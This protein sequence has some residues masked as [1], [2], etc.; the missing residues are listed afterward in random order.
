VLLCLREKAREV[1]KS[2]IGFVKVMMAVLSPGDLEPHLPAV[3]EGLMLWAGDAKNRFRAKIKVMLTKLCRKFGYDAIQQLV[4][5][6]DERLVSHIKK[7]KARQDKRAKAAKAQS[8][9][10]SSGGKRF[11][12]LVDSDD[13][14]IDSDD[15]MTIGGRTMSMKSMGAGGSIAGRSIASMRSAARSKAATAK[16]AAKSA[17]RSGGAR[18]GVNVGSK[19]SRSRYGGSDDEDA[20]WLREAPAGDAAGTINLLDPSGIARNQ[21]SQDP[22]RMKKRAAA[23]ADPRRDLTTDA[24]SGR[25][26][27]PAD[28]AAMELALNPVAPEK[29]KGATS[30]QQWHS[31]RRETDMAARA[32]KAGNGGK[33][34]QDTHSASRFASK[35]AKGDVSRKDDQLKPYA[36]LPLDPKM[37][38][39]RNKRE[40]VG[41]FQKGAVG[42]RLGKASKRKEGGTRGKRSGG[43]R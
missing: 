2:S 31:H 3:V 33:Q 5:E 21:S 18:T 26:I 11:D 41:Q 9:A 32:K 42:T 12:E 24:D 7:E 43:G 16:S 39:A 17:A 37:M 29:Y 30:G 38:S 22:K 27:V 4:P 10:S 36:Y 14:Y 8:V 35:K 40:A 15:D 19:R 28:D 6:G 34:R 13:E 20:T 25:I 23:M 1:I